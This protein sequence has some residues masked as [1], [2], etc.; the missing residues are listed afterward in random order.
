MLAPRDAVSGQAAIGLRIRIF[1]NGGG[2]G[3]ERY[4]PID[5]SKRMGETLAAERELNPEVDC[6]EQKPLFPKEMAVS[7]P[8]G[9]VHRGPVRAALR[10][11]P[12]IPAAEVVEFPAPVCPLQPAQVAVAAAAHN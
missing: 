2:G 11:A 4:F 8:E 10:E 1:E 7:A 5:D 6:I 3:L 12:S 9:A